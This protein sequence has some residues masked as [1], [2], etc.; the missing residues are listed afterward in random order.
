MND[1]ESFQGESF[2]AL[3]VAI[4]PRVHLTHRHDHLYQC[5]V[6]IFIRPSRIASL[7][8][9]DVF[10]CLSE[11]LTFLSLQLSVF[12]RVLLV[13][14]CTFSSTVTSFVFR[15]RLSLAR[16]SCVVLHGFE[17]RG[18]HSSFAATSLSR[19]PLASFCTFSSTMDLTRRPPRPHVSVTPSPPLL[20]PSWIAPRRSDG[21]QCLSE[22][23]TFLNLAATSG[24]YFLRPVARFRAP[25]SF[26]LAHHVHTTFISDPVT[27]LPVPPGCHYLYQSP[28][29]LLHASSTV[30]SA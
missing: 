22:P 1:H 18:H 29:G 4:T 28:P 2:W 8:K 25:K 24:A 14:F 27:T 7:G 13:P 12:S 10:Q 15:S 21:L 11:P 3:R 17:H 20:V 19:V 5:P 26:T 30:F 23:L 16:T 9:F 6:T